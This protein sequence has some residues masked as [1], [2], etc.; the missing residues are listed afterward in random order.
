VTLALFVVIGVTAFKRNR[1]RTADGMM[2]RA[3]SGT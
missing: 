2:S 3:A 1:A